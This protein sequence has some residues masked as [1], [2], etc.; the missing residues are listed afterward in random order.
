MSLN[1]FSVNLILF[2]NEWFRIQWNI[3][4]IG[5]Q[6]TFYSS[7]FFWK[8]G[9]R[10]WNSS[11]FIELLKCNLITWNSIQSNKNPVPL[12]RGIQFHM[13]TE[14]IH[15]IPITNYGESIFIYR[16]RERESFQF[17]LIT[18]NSFYSHVEQA[19]EFPLFCVKID[20]HQILL[21]PLI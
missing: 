11:Y 7:V 1:G 10:E 16:I 18:E 5:S 20:V 9:V 12:P 4:W 2:W 6:Y 13:Q 3:Q 14:G 19:V 21:F 17:L 8:D 15:S